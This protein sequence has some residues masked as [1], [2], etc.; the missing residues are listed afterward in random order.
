[1]WKR[2]ELYRQCK[3]HGVIGYSLLSAENW[4]VAWCRDK[5]HISGVKNVM[6]WETGCLYL[7]SRLLKCDL[8]ARQ[9]LEKISWM[10]MSSLGHS[11]ILINWS[12]IIW[13]IP[14]TKAIFRMLIDV[15]STFEKSTSWCS[16]KDVGYVFIWKWLFCNYR[17]GALNGPRDGSP[18]EWSPENSL[19]IL[20]VCQSE[21]ISVIGI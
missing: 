10:F 20:W 2:Q 3:L 7:L 8:K 1:M 5:T 6:S 15:F 13:H 4:R 14:N 17:R 21:L 9:F 11:L 18:P 12:S 16:R 19:D